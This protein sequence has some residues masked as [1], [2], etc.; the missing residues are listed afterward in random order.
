MGRYIP[1]LNFMD[2]MLSDQPVLQPSER[3]YQRLLAN[4]V[5]EA[6]DLIV[7]GVLTTSLLDVCDTILLPALR[8]AEQDHERGAIDA[9]K[10][11]AMIDHVA[12]LVAA[13]AA[14]TNGPPVRMKLMCLPAADRAD[15]L[16]GQL[17]LQLL[18]SGE[19]DADLVSAE[20]LKGEVL[21]HVSR[22]SPDV[23]YISAMPPSALAHARYLCK[24][25]RRR[26]ADVPI[27]VGLWDA[28]GDVQKA[29]E[30]LLEVGV[31][32]VVINAAG[33]LEELSRLRQPLL[34]GV[35]AKVDTVA[36]ELRLPAE[37]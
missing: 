15:A 16:A 4:D 28:Q 20:V 9:A 25:L 32:K 24:K 11:N 31:S 13:L 33:A 23:I 14:G 35:H 36:P 29:T 27:V 6:H 22:A 5:D 10:R 1:H 26:F 7:T 19:Y 8:F 37:P 34:Q 17:L 21:E 3:F 12:E 2:V 18:P 30:R